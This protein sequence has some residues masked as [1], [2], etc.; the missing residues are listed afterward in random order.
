MSVSAS[1]QIW[2]KKTVI[3]GEN[4]FIGNEIAMDSI[5]ETYFKFK[6][7]LSERTQFLLEIKLLETRLEKMNLD[8]D[9]LSSDNI[10]LK[11]INEKLED[12]LTVQEEI[13]QTDVLYYKEKAKG[14]FSAFLLGTGLGAIIVA[15]L[16]IL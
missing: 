3:N 7:S 10:T 14:K 12:R 4:A 9:F 8:V 11:S 15:L 13:H 5:M 16:T 1:S 2:L 6:N